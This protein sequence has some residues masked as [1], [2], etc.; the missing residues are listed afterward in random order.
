[1]L[2]KLYNHCVF[3][4]DNIYNLATNSES[5]R[6]ENRNANH[7]PKY[8]KNKG[9]NSPYPRKENSGRTTDGKHH[10]NSNRRQQPRKGGSPSGVK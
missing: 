1:M 2:T 3:R 10:S 6:D 4:V 7:D 9:S 5:K 8:R